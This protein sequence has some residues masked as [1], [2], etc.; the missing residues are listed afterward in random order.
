MLDLYEHFLG[1][2][3]SPVAGVEDEIILKSAWIAYT[4]NRDLFAERPYLA[5]EALKFPLAC[6]RFVTLPEQLILRR[7][8]KKIV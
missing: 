8:L 5:T 2:K 6:G 1:R 3:D 7:F 4:L